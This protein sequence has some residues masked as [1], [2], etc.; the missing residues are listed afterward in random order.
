MK[1]I[2]TDNQR[3]VLEKIA[4]RSKMDSWFQAGN[5]TVAT[6]DIR[7]LLDGATPHDV[8]TLTPAEVTTV[9][10]ILLKV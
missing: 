1:I 4:R 7:T 6:K 10:D 2:L 9:I 3:E 5:N 8:E